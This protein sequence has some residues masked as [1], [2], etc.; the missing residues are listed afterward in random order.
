VEKDKFEKV[1]LAGI[2]KDKNW[3]FGIEVL[4]LFVLEKKEI[5]FCFWLLFFC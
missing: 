4:L 3:H 5:W 1:Q 2:Q